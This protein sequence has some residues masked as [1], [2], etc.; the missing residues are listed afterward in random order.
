MMHDAV[1]GDV[2]LARSVSKDD[3]QLKEAQEGLKFSGYGLVEQA[4]S[5]L[6][7]RRS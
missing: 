4:G 3:A 2:L 5:A 7:R 1:R 6:T